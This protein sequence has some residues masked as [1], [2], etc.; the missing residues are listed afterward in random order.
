[1][2][3][4]VVFLVLVGR[5]FIFVAIRMAGIFRYPQIAALGRLPAYR[6]SEWAPANGPKKGAD[7][8]KE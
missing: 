1:M 3:H 2:L 8:P 5:I 4:F 6:Q 7:G